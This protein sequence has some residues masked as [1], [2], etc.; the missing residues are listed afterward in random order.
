MNT[1]E[2]FHLSLCLDMK[3][4]ITNDSSSR[5][6]GVDARV[7]FIQWVQQELNL[8]FAGELDI[9]NGYGEVVIHGNEHINAELY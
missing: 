6:K 9:S 5:Q 4:D 8:P 1:T 7:R 3:V 2:T